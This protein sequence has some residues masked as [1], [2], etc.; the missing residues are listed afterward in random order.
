MRTQKEARG[1]FIVFE[2]L[3]GVDVFQHVVDLGQWLRKDKNVAQVHPTREPSDGPVG[4]TIRQHLNRRT[5]FDGL[6]LP[7]LFAADRMDHLFHP[8]VGILD[9][10]SRGEHILCDRYY[11]STYAY[12]ALDPQVDLQ[13]IRQLHAHCRAPDLTIFIDVP[14]EQCLHMIVAEHLRGIH[15]AIFDLSPENIASVQDQLAQVRENY[16]HAIELLRNEGE[17]IEVV[18]KETPEI[19]NRELRKII[20]KA[21]EI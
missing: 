21:L 11:L 15:F 6:T 5:T 18:Q 7:V 10:L 2:G 3:D 13:W 17:T 16:L 14:V 4:L 1:K 9:R 19:I 20:S 12:Q 8:E